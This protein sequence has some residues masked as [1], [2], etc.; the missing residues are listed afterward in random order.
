M[1]GYSGQIPDTLGRRLDWQEAAVCGMD[2][3]L[4]FDKDRQHEART[5][6]VTR[7]PVRPACLAQIK[8]T[9]Q[10]EHRAHRSGVIAG[11]TSSERWRFDP[12]AHSKSDRPVLTVEDGTPCGSYHALVRHL[13]LG[14]HVD[15]KCWSAELARNRLRFVDRHVRRPGPAV[16]DEPDGPAAREPVAQPPR[17]PTPPNPGRT[18]KER[19]VYQLWT[20]G[21]TDL[22]VARRADLSTLAVRRIREALGL[23]PNTEP[24]EGM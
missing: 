21:L 12:T 13:W 9:E 15:P 20:R 17:R 4:F 7:C 22:S 19:H 10:G 24:N 18:P 5:A 1:G 14:E 2:P 6:C 23:V 8:E 3:E 16:V 11:L